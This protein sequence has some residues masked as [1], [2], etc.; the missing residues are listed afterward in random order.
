MKQQP[1][2]RLTISCILPVFIF[3][4]LHN[5]HSICSSVHQKF[6]PQRL[7]LHEASKYPAMSKENAEK[8]GSE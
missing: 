8:K 4:Q 3:F 7:S 5:S 2:T 1:L 6:N